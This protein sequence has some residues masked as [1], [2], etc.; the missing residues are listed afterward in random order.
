MLSNAS[1]N[2]SSNAPIGKMTLALLWQHSHQAI[3]W[4][5]SHPCSLEILKIWPGDIAVASNGA[6]SETS[7]QV[8][9][10]WRTVPGRYSD[11]SQWSLVL[12]MRP[13]SPRW[14]SS[15]PNIA[16]LL[17][18]AHNF[19]TWKQCTMYTSLWG[20]KKTVRIGKAYKSTSSLFVPCERTHVFLQQALALCCIV[21]ALS[22]IVLVDCSTAPAW[23]SDAVEHFRVVNWLSTSFY[24][25]GRFKPTNLASTHCNSQHCD[26]HG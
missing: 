12:R 6:A 18:E 20:F 26:A 5:L 2:A 11:D 4:T 1:S 15:N 7:G 8:G 16:G 22:C 23:C 24:M 13:T 19:V 21:L 17:Q 3:S 14:R 10:T 9:H 25:S